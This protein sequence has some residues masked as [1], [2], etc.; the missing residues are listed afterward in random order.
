MRPDT[1][2]PH[3]TT[4]QAAAEINRLLTER[5]STRRTTVGTL[6]DWRMDGKGPRYRR[7]SN[8]FIEYHPGDLAAFVD[9]YYFGARVPA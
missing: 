7:I 9:E 4:P 1:L 5:G 8:W 6:K 2:P 3:L